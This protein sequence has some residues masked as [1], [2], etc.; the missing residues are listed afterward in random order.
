MILCVCLNPA[1]QRTLTFKSLSLRRV[2]RAAS[3]RHSVGGKGVNVSRVATALGADAKLLLPL[4]GA[5]GREIRRLLRREGLSF[6]A[7][8]VSGE[9]RVCTTLVDAGLSS[10]TELV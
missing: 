10:V 3:A 6:T 5:R 4:G 2:N 8:D 9:T 7:V 1:L